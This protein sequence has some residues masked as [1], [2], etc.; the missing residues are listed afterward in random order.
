MH[1]KQTFIWLFISSLRR[2]IFTG[3]S[4]N[5]D[6]VNSLD[7]DPNRINTKYYG[8]CCRAW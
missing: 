6:I 1:S 7:V 3:N 4:V 2:K 5:L 8:K